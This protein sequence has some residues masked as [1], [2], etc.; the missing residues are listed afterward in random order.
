MSAVSAK[1][2]VENENHLLNYPTNICTRWLIIIYK[3]SGSDGC[4][5]MGNK[6]QE[7]QVN[8]M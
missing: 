7:H 4:E 8:D 6:D 3:Q 5:L 2:A 1:S